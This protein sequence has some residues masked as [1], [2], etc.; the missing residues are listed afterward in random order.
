MPRTPLLSSDPVLA[1][2]ANNADWCELVCRANAVATQ[3]NNR[4]WSAASRSPAQ[5]PDAVTLTP[6]V[7]VRE[8]LGTIDNT[9]GASVKDSYGTLELAGGG[10]RLLFKA[11]W[12]SRPPPA[13][14]GTAGPAWDEV[15]D[16]HSLREWA[17]AH[18]IGATLTPAV[19]ADPAVVIL[20]RRSAGRT[21]GGAI[22]NRSATVLGVSNVFGE[23][24]AE[25][26][27]DVVAAIPSRFRRLP[28]VGYE[29][30]DELVH[31]LA[32]GFEQIGDLS[33]WHR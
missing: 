31:C 17:D 6:A 5:Y 13:P 25:L 27:N 4:W 20:R 2:A 3:R 21:D 32:A 33:V 24:G 26:W 9:D 22:L 1:A 23:G 11:H 30:G 16:P 12:I 10:F 18:G 15:S 29:R 19:L 7:K 14:A 8:L 28:L